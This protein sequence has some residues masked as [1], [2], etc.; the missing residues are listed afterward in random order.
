[1]QDRLKYYLGPNLIFPTGETVNSDS[2]GQVQQP[3]YAAPSAPMY[4]PINN[5]VAPAPQPMNV[6][7]N[8]DGGAS[9]SDK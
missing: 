5:N 7:Q 2:F 1:M 4:V 6:P 8:S 3:R 9:W